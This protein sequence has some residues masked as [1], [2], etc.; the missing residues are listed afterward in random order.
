MSCHQDQVAAHKNAVKGLFPDLTEAQL[1]G[2]W[3]LWAYHYA[4]ERYMR[5][6][7]LTSYLVTECGVP[8][9]DDAKKAIKALHR[10][11]VC[12]F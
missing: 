9:V 5:E 10:F 11:G 8:H 12:L 1:E 3:A 4:G 7:A 2:V 6:D